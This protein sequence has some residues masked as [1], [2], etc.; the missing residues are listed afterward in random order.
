MIDFVAQEVGN[1]M[2]LRLLGQGSSA[3]VYLAKHKFQ[4]SYVAMKIYSSPAN[5][6]YIV[7]HL[8]FPQ[9]LVQF[10]YVVTLI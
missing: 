2:L 8:R 1:Y 7:R 3:D 4:R 6:H 10:N 5:L 9:F